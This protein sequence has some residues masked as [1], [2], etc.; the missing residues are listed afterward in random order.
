MHVSERATIAM[1]TPLVVIIL[2][3]VSCVTCRDNFLSRRLLLC[4]CL[5]EREM[6]DSYDEG[7]RL[8]LAIESQDIITDSGLPTS[9]VSANGKSYDVSFMFSPQSSEPCRTAMFELFENNMKQMYEETWGWNRETKLKEIFARDSRFLVVE[10]TIVGITSLVAWMMI[11]FEYDD[12]D[13]PEHPVVF[14]YE[15]HV[16]PARRSES[17]CHETRNDN[18]SWHGERKRCFDE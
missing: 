13:A 17:I 3:S 15:L 14:L 10:E 9:I 2:G 18:V 1:P 11:K 4:V 6:D 16:D 12:L 8:S 7:A 5:C